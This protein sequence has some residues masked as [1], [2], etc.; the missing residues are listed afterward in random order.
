MQIFILTIDL[1]FWPTINVKY[2]TLHFIVK[3]KFLLITCKINVIV[4][5]KNCSQQIKTNTIF[6]SVYLRKFPWSKTVWL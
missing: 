2:M 1:N 4:L 6:L 3:L 5:Y